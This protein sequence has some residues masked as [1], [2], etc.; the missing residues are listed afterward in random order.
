MGRPVNGKAKVSAKVTVNRWRLD[1]GTKSE[2]LVCWVTG[3]GAARAAH[4]RVIANLGTEM[5]TDAAQA[6]GR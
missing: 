4:A 5:D 1:R 6:R 3:R 2:N